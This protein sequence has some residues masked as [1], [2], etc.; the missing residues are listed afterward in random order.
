MQKK[1][2]ELDPFARPWG[3]AQTYYNLRNY[4][5]AISDA[6]LRLEN[7][8]NDVR[9][10][11]FI[12]RSLFDQGKYQE[13]ADAWANLYRAVNAPQAAAEA[14]EAYQ[15][16]GYRALVRWQLRTA[17]NEAKAHYL[18]PVELADLHAELGQREQTLAL[19]EEGFQHHSPQLLWI[20]T[21]KAYDFLHADS[22]YQSLIHRIGLP[23]AY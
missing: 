4:D 19:L 9:L 13:A 15:A 10:H 23:P 3:M 12:A 22:H 20:Q 11:F 5:A 21:E 2:M 14:E 1:Q 8:P 18:S 6:R 16:G 17:E 7:S